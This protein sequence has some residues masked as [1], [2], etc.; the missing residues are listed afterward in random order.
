MKKQPLNAEYIKSAISPSY[1]YAHELRNTSS[2]T[3]DWSD[4]GLCPFHAEKNAGSFHVNMTTGA[5][6]CFSCGAKGGD[7]IAFTMA[8]YDLGFFD[9][10]IKLADDWG[11]V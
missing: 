11:L 1:F 8:Q 10:L 9:A 7:I 2:Q 6:K 5:F 3:Q 4:G